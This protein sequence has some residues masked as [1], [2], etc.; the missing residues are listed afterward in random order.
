[1]EASEAIAKDNKTEK[2]KERSNDKENEKEKSIERENVSATFATCSVCLEAVVV[3]GDR[4][5]AKLRCAHQ[6]HLDC[7]GSAFNVKGAMQCP[8]CRHVED[9]QWLYASALRTPEDFAFEDYV[10]DDDFDFSVDLSAVLS[11][12]ED[13]PFSGGPLLEI[14]PFTGRPELETYNSHWGAC[15]HLGH[16]PHPQMAA[17]SF[18]RRPERHHIGSMVEGQPFW[19]MLEAQRWG[20]AD[21]DRV[22]APAPPDLALSGQMRIGRHHGSLEM[23]S[24]QLPGVYLPG[25]GQ[26]GPTNWLDDSSYRL[27]QSRSPLLRNLHQSAQNNFHGPSSRNIR[28]N[29]GG[30][31]FHGRRGLSPEQPSRHL[32][33]S[34]R[35]SGHE[36]GAG[37]PVRDWRWRAEALGLTARA[38]APQPDAW[39]AERSRSPR[40]TYT[41]SSVGPISGLSPLTSVHADG[42]P[43]PSPGS[44]YDVM[45]GGSSSGDM[46]SAGWRRQVY[47]PSPPPFRSYDRDGPPGSEFRCLLC[48]EVVP[49]RESLVPSPRRTTFRDFL[50]LRHHA[51]TRHQHDP[52]MGAAL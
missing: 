17:V 40:E 11:A 25:A 30:N 14:S 37:M 46:H 50:S 43:G 41:S 10:I 2:K 1:M 32:G 44:T 15:P 36:V 6:F 23:E 26:S 4:A 27:R 8:N 39:E 42:L 33:G 16:C 21:V 29:Y 48:A 19:P 28:P 9:G 52:F 5:T 13:T 38:E 49:W 31:A 12:V 51:L 7:I 24:H 3:D 45:H 47:N 35:L 20:P 22:R 18:E 34:S